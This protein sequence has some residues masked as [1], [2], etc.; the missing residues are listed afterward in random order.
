MF[1]MLINF[2]KRFSGKMLLLV[3]AMFFSNLT[4]A[5]GVSMIIPV[6][7][8]LLEEKTPTGKIY[9]LITN[10]YGLF[11]ILVNQ[12]TILFGLISVFIFR[13]IFSIYAKKISVK[14][15]AE[16][17]FENQNHLLNSILGSKLKFFLNEKQGVLINS[18]VQENVRSSNAFVSMSL[19]I[20][21]ILTAFV[22]ILIAV[23]VSGKL[24][25]IAA[26]IGIVALV[27]L[28]LITRKTRYFGK[29]YTDLNEEI[30]SNLGE[31]FTGIKY[32]KGSA[33]ETKVAGRFEKMSKSFSDVWYN[34]AFI[35][36]SLTIYAQ[37]IAVIVLSGILVFGK[38]YHL[39]TSELIVFL[40]AFQRLLPTLSYAQSIKNDFES[41]FP[42]FS[43]IEEL[44]A[45]A[46]VM[47]EKNNGL[48][49]LNFKNEI[50]LNNV[51]FSHSDEVSLFE[52]L[53][54]KIEAFKVTSF[55]GHS[56]SGKSTLIDML[57]GFYELKKGTILYDGVP[58]SSIKVK[59]LRE[60]V[61]YVSQETFLFHDTIKANIIFENPNAT[62]EEIEKAAK[63]AHA[64]EFIINLENGYEAVVGD[65][66]GKLSGG[67]KQRIALARALL[68]KPSILILDEATSAL[69]YESES[70]IKDT[71]NQLKEMK[72]V[73]ILVIAHRLT[74]VKDSDKIIVLDKGRI[75]EMGNWEELTRDQ[76]SF[77]SRSLKHH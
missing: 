34:V 24:A 67:Q 3:V 36:N 60:K 18:I 66:G 22:Y 41:N 11:A 54:F 39:S 55:L 37:P 49:F 45:K 28:K 63:L 9:E 57:L 33:L 61:A 42:A 7:Q 10:F 43:R 6:F 72:S 1:K 50:I 65:R 21:S 77:I 74:T 71:I 12:N 59:S 31:T 47:S 32:I 69:D 68:K 62:N 8:Q 52:N 13:A 51:D 23:M 44:L 56:G 48:D 15:S 58:L 16:Y 73:T 30:Q 4:E 20:T 27:P 64:H 76:N 38:Q 25:I 17:L 53:N 26:V 46:N 5:L 14:I 35:S 70:L 29:M 40:I 75:T 19:W 2:C